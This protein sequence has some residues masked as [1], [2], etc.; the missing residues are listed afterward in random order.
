MLKKILPPSI[1]R[2]HL[3]SYELVL[4]DGRRIFCRPVCFNMV[5]SVEVVYSLTTPKK[6]SHN[7]L[8]LAQVF[9]FQVYDSSARSLFGLFFGL[10]RHLIS[11]WS[12]AA[13]T[14]SNVDAKYRVP[15]SKE[16]LSPHHTHH[17]IG[18]TCFIWSLRKL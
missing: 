17:L 11:F 8:S 14:C 2:P 4:C 5:P 16:S 3:L 15:I 7:L 1:S 12:I 18:V 6:S 10:S 9:A 13:S